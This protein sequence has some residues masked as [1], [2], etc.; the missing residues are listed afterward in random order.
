MARERNLVRENVVVTN[1]TVVRDVNADHKKVARSDACR[2]SFPART[3]KSAELANDVVVADLEIAG[4]AFELNILRLTAD[5]GMLK[6]P[7]PGADSGEPF[8]YSIGPNLAIWANF[9]VILDDGCGMNG[10]F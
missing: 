10:H 4:L 2:Q 8:D 9:D 5:Y 3:V 6:N 1:D 7:V